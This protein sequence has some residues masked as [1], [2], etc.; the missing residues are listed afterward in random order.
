MIGT[1]SLNDFYSNSFKFCAVK[2]NYKS[3]SPL[4]IIKGKS[5]D[6]Q[7]ILRYLSGTVTSI[8]NADISGRARWS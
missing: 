4:L 7:K 2:K 6:L 1:R 5:R 8:F 3:S